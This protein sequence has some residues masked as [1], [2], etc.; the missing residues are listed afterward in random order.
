[1]NLVEKAKAVDLVLH[2]LDEEIKKFQS[3]SLL[4][5]ALGCG[6]CCFKPD[7]EATP[8]E[9]LPLALKIFKTVKLKRGWTSLKIT[10]KKKSVWY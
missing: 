3:W 4:G 6:K 2:E 8:L 5:C 7:I 9:F 1:M 10:R